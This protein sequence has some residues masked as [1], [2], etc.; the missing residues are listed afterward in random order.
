MLNPNQDRLDYGRMLAPLPGFRLDFAVGTTYSLDLD[1]L[2][3]AC[4]ALGLSEETDSAL[5]NNPICL[6]EALRS[7]GDRI[8]LFCEGGQIHLPNHVTPLYALLEKMVFQ[9]N[10]EKRRGISRYPSFH[11]KF[12]ILRY[13]NDE[14]EVMYRICVLSRNL[15]FDRSWDVTFCMDGW[16]V[17]EVTQKNA[18]V[19]DFLSYLCNYAG[20]KKD[21]IRRM[22][23]E[24]PKVQFEL[25]S[26]EFYDFD[27]IP[28][29]IRKRGI[30]HNITNYPLFKDSFHEV[31]IMSPFL[32]NSVIK[33]FNERNPHIKHTEY[34]LITRVMSL[35][36]L[37]AKDCS[38]FKI[39]TL[40]DAIVDGESLISEANAAVLQQDIHAKLYM[41]RKYSDVDLY[42]GSLN[43]SRNAI[44][45][46]I[47]FMIRLRSKYRYLN[48][49]KLTEQLFCGE[50]GAAGN[51]FQ[52][53]TL[54]AEATPELPE[55]PQS[56]LDHVVKELARN[57]PHAQIIP[58]GEHYEAH[59]HLGVLDTPYRVQISPLF[60]NKH[61]DYAEDVV[62]T[63]LSL[64]QLSEFYQ[65]SVSDGETEIRRVLM[66]PT[67][68]MPEDREKA[69]ISN[70]ISEER[71][72]YQY[73]AFLLGD[74][75]MLSSLE[76]L[77]LQKDG[78]AGAANRTYQIP[79]LYEKMLK[80]A[81]TNPQ[82]LREIDYLLK[83]VAGDGVIPEMFEELYK[84]FRK[85]VKLD[86]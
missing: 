48:L 83:T 41:V 70:V 79:A 42:L 25:D 10:V 4:I 61:T 38:N 29:G 71:C 58:C 57:K 14:K 5:Q 15:T 30:D 18:P 49:A 72:F 20:D 80:T 8:A 56:L 82:K 44:S 77:E 1:A 22:I 16:P 74:D 39:Y 78:N 27:F 24:L 53:V 6:L 47:E 73:I 60:S 76:S 34:V 36:H 3:G 75:H 40:K 85:V 50:E 31:L 13:V 33:D 19:C 86:D 45:G 65:I 52:Q 66:I 54:D 12:W 64:T 81:S 37:K 26:K 46:N 69:I 7:T 84:T 51:P 32:S 28:V 9:I 63:G 67:S 43:A 17:G 11:P 59:V 23:R 21:A 55:E 68:D 35:G 2:V 62:F